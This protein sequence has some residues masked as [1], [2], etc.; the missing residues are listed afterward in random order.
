MLKIKFAVIWRGQVISKWK[1]LD[2]SVSREKPQLFT[3]RLVPDPKTTSS[4]YAISF[5]VNEQ[6]FPIGFD[7]SRQI[8]ATECLDQRSICVFSVVNLDIVTTATTVAFW[9]READEV[10][11]HML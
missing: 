8:A 5:E 9:E 11:T 6:F 3:N 1:L 7:I 10:Q 2:S 4:G